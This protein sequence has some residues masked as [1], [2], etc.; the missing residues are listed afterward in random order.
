MKDFFKQTCAHLASQLFSAKR[1]A[2]EAGKA[3]P[4]GLLDRLI[5]NALIHRAAVQGDHENLRSFLAQYWKGASGSAFYK[6]FS[7]RFEN[8][9]LTEHYCVVE[10]LADLVAESPASYQHFYEIGCG[11]GQVLNHLSQ[12]F[13]GFDEFVGLDINQSII[14]KN[15]EFYKNPKLAFHSSDAAD[16][17]HKNSKKGSILMS[18]GGVM[19]YFLEKELLEMFAMLKQKSPFIISLVEPLYDCYD[20]TRET[21]SRTSG[22][23]HS[24]S[25]NHAHLLQQAGFTICYDIEIKTEFRWVAMIAKG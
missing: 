12:K 20:R 15:R 16:W 10:A 22:K 3:N 5:S 11:D 18:Y 7:D 1:M 17:L 9:F 19:E 23:E 24:F 2:L 25:H 8:S 14:E 13:I 21:H 4:T 6:A